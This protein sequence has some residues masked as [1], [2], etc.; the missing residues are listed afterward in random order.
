MM[1]RRIPE[2]RILRINKDLYKISGLWQKLKVITRS[3]S[4][5]FYRFGV[6]AC[7]RA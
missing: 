4:V 5:W 2:N 7:P 3:I 6:D 1:E